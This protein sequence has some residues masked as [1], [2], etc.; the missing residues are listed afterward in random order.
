MK[1]DEIFQIYITLECIF[2]CKKT[3]C[4][5]KKEAKWEMLV[6]HAAQ[7]IIFGTDR[8]LKNI[9]PPPS[10]S[11]YLESVPLLTSMA[12]GLSRKNITMSSNQ[13]PE[14]YDGCDVII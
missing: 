5:S 10:L 8:T 2:D 9:H 11:G 1:K 6:G 3:Q 14:T 12:G 13:L 7:L 4:V